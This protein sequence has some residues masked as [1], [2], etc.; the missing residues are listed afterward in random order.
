MKLFSSVFA[1][2]M[3]AACGNNSGLKQFEPRDPDAWH[4]IERYFSPPSE[5]ADSFGSY[6]DLLIDDEGNKINTPR[7]WDDRRDLIKSEWMSIMG[8]WPQVISDNPL[9]RVDSVD[10]DGFMR[11]TVEFQWLPGRVTRGYL[12]VPDDAEYSPAV[13]TVFYEP[14]TAVGIGGKPLR[15]FALQ[16]AR[17]GFVTLSLGTAETT[18]AQTY[19]LYYPS[20]DSVSMQPLNTLAYAAANAFESLAL[21]S[22]V[23]S[24]R[25]GIMGHSYGG[26]W[27][28]FASCL[29]DKFACA[30]WGDP[31]I[32]FDESKGGNVNYWAPW[33]LGW[34]SPPWDNPWA[35]DGFKDARG[36]YN[37]LKSTHDL[38]E[39]HALMAPR[40]FFVSGGEAD[41]VSRWKVLNHAVRL[42]RMLGYENRVGMS[43]REGHSPTVEAN[44]AVYDFFRAFL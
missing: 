19:S 12:L 39:L 37:E 22:V 27:A 26:K 31:G 23:D 30:A 6:T 10:C 42:N 18:L 9:K 41:E 14:E 36:V 40:P 2:L 28:M 17:R 32:V 38:H 4:R 16:L 11:Y 33:Y 43:N 20:V 7:A 13:I 5:Y 8:E 34:Y 3:M 21:E 44:E 24:S 35:P 25:I 29:Y 15:D 1:V